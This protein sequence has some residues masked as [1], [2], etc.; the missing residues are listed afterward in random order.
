MRYGKTKKSLQPV[1]KILD[2][3]QIFLRT[4]H[5]M[6]F[7]VS[8]TG[9]SSGFTETMPDEGGK[10]YHGLGARISRVDENN[11]C[12]RTYKFGRK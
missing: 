1:A 2:G 12:V 3:H 8:N 5:E 4:S 11:K 7:L 9:K 6:D 10:P